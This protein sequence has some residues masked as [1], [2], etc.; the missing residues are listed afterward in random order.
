MK[1]IYINNYHLTNLKFKMNINIF[2]SQHMLKWLL[3]ITHESSSVSTGALV[4]EGSNHTMV[5][6]RLPNICK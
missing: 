4:P 6:C 3:V 1:K 2:G 5:G